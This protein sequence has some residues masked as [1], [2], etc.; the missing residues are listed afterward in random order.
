MVKNKA[1][2]T[3][4][5]HVD[6][7]NHWLREKVQNKEINVHWV[8]TNSMPADGLIKPLLADKHAGFVKQLGLVDITHRIHHS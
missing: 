5:C 1:I 3:R 4:L 8:D 6:I 2:Q 7:H